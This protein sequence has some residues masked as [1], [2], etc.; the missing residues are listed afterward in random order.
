MKR[1]IIGLL[2][3]VFGILFSGFLAAVSIGIMIVHWRAPEHTGYEG[4]PMLALGVAATA[5]LGI[6]IYRLGVKIADRLPS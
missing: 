6:V 5:L 4:N 3:M 1:K 2:M